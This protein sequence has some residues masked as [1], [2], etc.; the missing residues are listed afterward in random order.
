MMLVKNTMKRVVVSASPES[1]VLQAARLMIAH[2]IG[3]LPVVNSQGRLV[4]VVTLNTIL[5][6][7][8][9]NYFDYLENLSFVHN[10]GA[11]EDFLPKDVAEIAGTALQSI[12]TQPV[13]VYEDES[14]FRA[15]TKMTRHNLVDLPVIN[16]QEK[17]VGLASHVDI[18][19]AFLQKW[20]RA[21]GFMP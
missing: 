4:G 11:L 9:P 14:I 12:M 17:L 10:F 16:Q 18:G 21:K 19:T 8:I 6:V 13:A 20:I 7:F 1:T 5:D 15:A 2:G 3:T